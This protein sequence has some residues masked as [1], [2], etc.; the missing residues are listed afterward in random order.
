MTKKRKRER[1]RVKLTEPAVIP[2]EI[3]GT[4]KGGR[5]P[6]PITAEQVFDLALIHC[7][8]DEIAAC[9]KCTATTIYDRFPEA[10]RKGHEQGQM[11][12]KRKM[13]EKAL[14]GDTTLLIWISKQRLGYRDRP[15]E[16]ATQI[17]FN[18]I[19]SEIPK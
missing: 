1:K 13:H 10:L 14:A 16:E 18:V 11:S 2:A 4:D 7:T 15:A 17:N 12:I 6:L 5:P 19:A 3:Q 8:A 9:L